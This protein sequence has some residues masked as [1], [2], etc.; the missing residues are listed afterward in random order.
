V[1]SL[2]LL[3]YNVIHLFVGVM[4]SWL[5]VLLFVCLFCRLLQRVLFPTVLFVCFFVDV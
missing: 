3:F 4:E 1:L 5:V 2:E